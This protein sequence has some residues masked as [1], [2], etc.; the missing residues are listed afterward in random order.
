MEI[1]RIMPEDAA[2]TQVWELREAVLRRP[3]GLSLK[4]EDLSSE[5]QEITLAALEGEE[6]IGC[7]LLRPLESGWIKLRQMAVAEKMQGR[8]VGRALVQAAEQTAFANGYT[9]IEL[10]ARDVAAGFYRK[11][12]YREEGP[13]FTEVNIPHLKMVKALTV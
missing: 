3:L 1:K 5:V 4:D 6:V 9:H 10:H 7:V 13:M 11:L 12:G 8:N 2:S